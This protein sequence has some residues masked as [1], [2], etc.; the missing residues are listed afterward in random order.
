MTNKTLS[1]PDLKLP[2]PKHEVRGSLL[3]VA[4][5]SY[6]GRLTLRCSRGALWELVVGS[7][8]LTDFAAVY[9]RVST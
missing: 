3:K 6:T 2:T 7:W 9:F 1:T 8:E 4:A 5:N